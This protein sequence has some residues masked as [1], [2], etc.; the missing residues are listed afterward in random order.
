MLII[1][2]FVFNLQAAIVKKYE[3]EQLP[4]YLRSLEKLLV[5]NE[6]GDRFFVGSKVR[7]R[8]DTLTNVPFNYNYRQRLEATS[9]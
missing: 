8:Y 6:G 5:S 9:Q 3:S 7:N 1:T 4:Q 2:V